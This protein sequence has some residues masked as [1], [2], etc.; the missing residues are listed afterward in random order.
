[1]LGWVGGMLAF[2]VSGSGWGECKGHTH[3]ADVLMETRR[4]CFLCQASEVL[5]NIILTLENCKFERLLLTCQLC[6]PP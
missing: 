4:T 3:I 5:H 6:R 1:M 2:S